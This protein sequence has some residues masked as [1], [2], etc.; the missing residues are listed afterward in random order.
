MSCGWPTSWNDAITWRVTTSRRMGR[1]LGSVIDLNCCH[2]LAPSIAA[3]SYRSTAMA[4]I[5]ARR[6]IVLKPIVHHKVATRM[7]IHAHGLVVSQ[8]GLHPKVSA[9]KSVTNPALPLNIHHQAS[10][11]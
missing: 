9:M 2:L 6:M 10:A 11:I 4:C 7:E 8:F 1:R 5:P 3:D